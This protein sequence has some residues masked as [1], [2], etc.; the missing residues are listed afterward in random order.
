MRGEEDTFV[1]DK[2]R[3]SNLRQ[4][5]ELLQYMEVTRR[6]DIVGETL[7]CVFQSEFLTMKSN[8]ARDKALTSQS[9]EV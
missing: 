6:K 3:R 7:G 8:T 1:Y 5:C 4:E 2:C 9:K